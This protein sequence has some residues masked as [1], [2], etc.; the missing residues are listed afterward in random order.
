MGFAVPVDTI[1][2]VVPQLI[3]RGKYIRPALGVQVDDG[4]NQAA[5]RQLGIEGV[6]VLEV[7][8]GS[9]AEAAG[10]KGATIGTDGTLVPGDK[11]ITNRMRRCCAIQKP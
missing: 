11:R 7:L 10:L 3:A 8:P 1:N 2:R 9:P 4:L 5:A 6:L